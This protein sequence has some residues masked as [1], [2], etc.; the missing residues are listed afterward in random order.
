MT[1]TRTPSPDPRG[2]PHGPE[3]VTSLSPQLEP[4]SDTRR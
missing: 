2:L 1:A 4:P 3:P